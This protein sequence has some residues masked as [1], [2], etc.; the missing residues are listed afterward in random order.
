MVNSSLC[1]KA[2]VDILMLWRLN[3]II[4]DDVMELYIFLIII[5]FFFII[6]YIMSSFEVVG[7][8]SEYTSF[9]MGLLSICK[10]N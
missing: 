8:L 4:C 5:K 10:A 9:G 1:K 3:L 6:S 2:S 7:Y